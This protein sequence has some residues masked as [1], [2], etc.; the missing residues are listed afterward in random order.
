MNYY[1]Y[2]TYDIKIYLIRVSYKNLQI[3]KL[4]ILIIMYFLAIEGSVIFSILAPSASELKI[5]INLKNSYLDILRDKRDIERK[6]RIQLRRYNHKSS[7]IN[8]LN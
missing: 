5:L 4:I 3:Y 8:S 1:L 7:Q 2:C 6:L